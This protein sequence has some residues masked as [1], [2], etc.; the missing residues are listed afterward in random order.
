MRV[1][2]ALAC[3]VALATPA[4]AVIGGD[5][6]GG[7]SESTMQCVRREGWDF[8]IVRSYMSYGAPDPNAR[9]MLSRA[10]SAGIP[11]RDVYHFPCMGKISARDQIKG[12][13]D[14]VG[15]DNF[16]TMWLDIETNPSPGCGWSG[17]KADS[18]KFLADM[19][20]EGKRL[21][22]RVGVYSS[23]YEWGQTVGDGCRA[24]HDAGLPLWYAHYDGRQTF[25]DFT[26]FGG[27]TKPAMK[28]YADHVGYCGINSDADW[29]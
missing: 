14:A 29:Y 25:S 5:I 15:K 13:V 19:I 2:L 3:V 1:F 10:H 26:S 6:S 27:W 28:Q 21:G 23:V 11:Y 8:M 17:N 7:F 16:G 20:A 4:L 22:I 12:D 18:C 24:G 9:T